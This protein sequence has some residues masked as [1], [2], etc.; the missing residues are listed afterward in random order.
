[1]Y[2]PHMIHV[3]TWDIK[4]QILAFLQTRYPSMINML[5]TVAGIPQISHLNSSHCSQPAEKRQLGAQSLAPG[6]HLKLF[7]STTPAPL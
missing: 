5:I 4:S 6:R 3:N 1:M 2:K 7:A